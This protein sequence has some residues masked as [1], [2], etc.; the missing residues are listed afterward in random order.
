MTSNNAIKNED[1][2]YKDLKELSIKWDVSYEDLLKI[3]RK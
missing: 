3:I 1:N 2:R